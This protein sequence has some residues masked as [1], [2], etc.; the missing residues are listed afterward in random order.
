MTPSCPACTFSGGKEQHLNDCP[1]P[2][3]RR[4]IREAHPS[5]TTLERTNSL[6]GDV[7]LRAMPKIEVRDCGNFA[8]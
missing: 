1:L 5:T 7:D 6:S 4:A 2:Q 8:L 3:E